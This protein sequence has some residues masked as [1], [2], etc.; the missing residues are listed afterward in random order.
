MF[1]VDTKERRHLDDDTGAWGRKEP[2]QQTKAHELD[3]R[4]N[5]DLHS[6]LLGHWEHEIDRQ[7]ETRREM[8][9]D[10]DMYDGPGQW[11]EEERAILE[12][13]GQVP[14]VF[15]VLYTT[16]NWV[17]GTERRMKT[18]FSILPRR[19][20]AAKQARRKSELFKHVT[21]ANHSHRQ[22][23]RAFGEAVRAGLSFLETGYNSDSDLEPV[24]DRHESW[25][26]IIWDS[27]CSEPDMSD[28]RYI[29]RGKWLDVDVLTAKFPDRKGI[30]LEST[31]MVYDALMGLDNTGDDAMDSIEMEHFNSASYR[32]TRNVAERPRVRAY[33]IWFKQVSDTDT[34]RGGDFHG[35]IFDPW[36]PGHIYEVSAGRAHVVTKPKER[37]WVAIATDS[38]LLHLAPSPY[39]H[40]RFP[41]TPIWGNRRAKD[42]MP[43]G[44]IRNLRDLQRDLNKRA[45]K[46]LHILSSKRAFVEE[47]SVPDLDEFREEVARPDSVIVY[48]ANKTKPEVDTDFGVASGHHELMAR[49]QEM[50]QQGSG[51]TDENLGRRTNATSG[52]AIERRQTQGA[53][54]TAHYF[55]NYS[56]A[57]QIHSEKILSNVEQYYT[58][59]KEIRIT[60][61][62]GKPD[63]VLIN[64]PKDQESQISMSRADFV[65]A[66]YDWNATYR[67]AQAEALFDLATKL[68]AT[69]P[70]L[71][72]QII[73]LLVELLD[74]PNAEEIVKRIRQTTGLI[75]PDADL[76]NPDE[77]TASILAQKEAAG[78]AQAMAAEAELKAMIAKA[79]EGMAK[80]RK[81]TAEA[82]E[83]ER[84]STSTELDLLS[85]AIDA[86]IKIYGQEGVA[87][88]ADQLLSSADMRANPAAALPPEAMPPPPGPPPG[89]MAPPQPVAA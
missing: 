34:M 57:R 13:R 77:D 4:E 2:E 44:L 21:D 84:A 85:K 81:T 3:S 7:A 1:E 42:N 49:D 32:R 66:E 82:V 64:D 53:L 24:Y 30:I 88:I 69:A 68:A 83:K 51:V 6:V 27:T 15:N 71:V 75:D 35:Q 17:T 20:V 38:G 60:S 63:F 52:I 74:I 73:D 29:M 54:A 70:Q 89:A 22:Y 9:L 80:A 37:I 5:Q 55:E 41:F 10:E 62:R 48:R 72:M 58:D 40:N 23:S 59:E 50:I 16:C 39:R 19:K 78:Q 28:A 86:A 36:S 43:Y 11:T 45:A 8:A 87:M 56:F 46:S 33:E 47:G 61:D 18:D 14:L 31:S 79:E 25:R 65:L 26:N 12:E 76:E 67:Q